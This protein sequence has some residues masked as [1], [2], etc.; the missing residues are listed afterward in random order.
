MVWACRQYKRMPAPETR[1]RLGKLTLWTE[2]RYYAAF[3]GLC[4]TAFGGC[5]VRQF[6]SLRPSVPINDFRGGRTRLP[7][8]STPI[9]EKIFIT[10]CPLL[11]VGT[12]GS[13][14]KPK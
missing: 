2:G 9:Q 6:S 5:G 7:T 1:C 10:L 4:G 13:V 14:G 8:S 12:A 11:V 3:G